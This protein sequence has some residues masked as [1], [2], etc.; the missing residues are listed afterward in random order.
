MKSEVT[1]FGIK[2]LH[3]WLIYKPNLLALKCEHNIYTISY[4]FYHPLLGLPDDSTQGM[5]KHV[6]Y[7]VSTVFTLQCM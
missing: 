7:Y 4:M 6:G 2:P 5:L 3:I 1:V